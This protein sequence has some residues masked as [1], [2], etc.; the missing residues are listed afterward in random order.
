MINFKQ[1]TF[2]DKKVIDAAFAGNE[3]RACD[4]CFTNLYAWNAKFKT[5]YAIEHRTIF[6]RFQDSDGQTYYMMPIGKMP[7]RCIQINRRRCENKQNTIPDER[8][9]V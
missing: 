5:V 3:Y 1:I 2:S 4:F 9:L 8:H 7:Y 6:L